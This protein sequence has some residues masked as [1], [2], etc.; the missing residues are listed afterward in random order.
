[1]VHFSVAQGQQDVQKTHDVCFFVRATC[2]CALYV[3]IHL[4]KVQQRQTEHTR[5][6]TKREK[7]KRHSGIATS[8]TNVAEKE[9]PN[10]NE[11]VLEPVET[12]LGP[13]LLDVLKILKAGDSLHVKLFSICCDI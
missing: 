7:N 9:Y 10:S 11:L 8:L 5:T 13:F 12:Q 3:C 6:N 1:M 2:M 4:H